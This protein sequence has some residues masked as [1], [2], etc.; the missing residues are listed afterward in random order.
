MSESHT[1]QP[2]ERWRRALGRALDTRGYTVDEWRLAA[3][4]AHRPELVSA[5]QQ[6]IE[7]LRLQKT[8]GELL[9]RD[10][11][12]EDWT[13]WL[14]ERFGDDARLL[15]DADPVGVAYGVRWCEIVLEREFEAGDLF[16]NPPEAVIQWTR[17]LP[18]T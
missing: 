18:A 13:P 15:A 17:D 11:L 8:Q 7:Q 10:T 16:D 5:V 14:A 1:T 6:V 9:E 2:P 12:N 4:A 3:L